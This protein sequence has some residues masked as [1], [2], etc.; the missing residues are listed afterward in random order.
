MWV[1]TYGNVSAGAEVITVIQPTPTPVNPT[2]PPSTDPLHVPS[3]G[4]AHGGISTS[5]IQ[6][7]RQ[8]GGWNPQLWSNREL[9]GLHCPRRE[10]LSA[11]IEQF[12]ED[13]ALD[14][15]PRV[16]VG[17]QTVVVPAAVVD[18]LRD[19]GH[20]FIVQPA[21]SSADLPQEEADRIR[22]LG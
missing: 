22:R 2:L 17:D 12:W 7:A 19:K 6:S 18:Y 11:L 9:V 15:L 21:R 16:H 1:A 5:A 13:P 10:D 14:G 4:H 8:G 20:A 3:E